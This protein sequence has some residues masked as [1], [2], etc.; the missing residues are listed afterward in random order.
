MGRWIL[1]LVFALLPL[2]AAAEIPVEPGAWTAHEE[3]S[4]LTDAHTLAEML[5]SVA[6]IS[7]MIG[8]PQRATLVFRCTGQEVNAFVAWPQVPARQSQSVVLS[9]PETLVRWRLDQGPIQADFWVI[10]DG[11]HGAGYF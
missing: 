9:L 6:P 1:A 11:G 7:N 3:T 4:A 5:D 8:A 2:Q 10:S